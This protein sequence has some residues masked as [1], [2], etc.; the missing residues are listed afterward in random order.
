M[1]NLVN[2]MKSLLAR[3]YNCLPGDFDKNENILTAP[4]GSFGRNYC[5]YNRFF[6]MVTFGN[7]CIIC[8][9]KLFHPFLREFIKFGD[10]HRLFEQ[11]ALFSLQ[12]ELARFGYTLGGSHHFFFPEKQVELYEIITLNGYLIRL[13]LSSFTV[14]N[15]FLTRFVNIIRKSAPIELWFWLTTARI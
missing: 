2:E 6:R 11:N 15:D 9:D 3:D 7:N 5:E 13:I 12:T 14:I 10:G 4:S 1:I 8:A